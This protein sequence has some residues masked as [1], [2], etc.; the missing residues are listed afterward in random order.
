MKNNKGFT[1]VELILYMSILSVLLSVL[2]AIFA[3]A[4]DV[5]L[6]SQSTSVVEQDRSFIMARLSYDM[7]RASSISIPAAL[8]GETNNFQIL[9]GGVDYTY[10]INADGNLVVTNVLGTERLNSYDSSISGFS[11]K[12]LGNPGQIE[13]TLK[14][15]FT[16]TSK[17]QRVSIGPETRSFETTLSLRRK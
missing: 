4:V 7:L 10:S 9:I 15:S 5:Q 1:L 8:G 13:D 14:I 17:T 12:R 11:V 6:E 2:S 16:I 3:M